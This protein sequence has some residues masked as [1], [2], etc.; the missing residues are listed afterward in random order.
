VADSFIA[1]PRR[2]LRIGE[3]VLASD[4]DPLLANV[5]VARA[6]K[7]AD[8]ATFALMDEKAA[9]SVINTYRGYAIVGSTKT[10]ESQ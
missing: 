8:D 5:A 2:D 7:S 9:R 3:A 10:K 4:L 1:S 6:A